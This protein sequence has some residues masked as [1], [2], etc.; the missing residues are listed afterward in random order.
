MLGERFGQIGEWAAPITSSSVDGELTV[1]A[2]RT[3]QFAGFGPFQAGTI[4]ERL[5]EFEPAAMSLAYESA[6]WMPSFVKSAVNRW[7]VR[8][9]S[10]ASCLR[11]GLTVAMS[12]LGVR[13][14]AAGAMLNLIV[15]CELAPLDAKDTAT[16]RLEAPLVRHDLATTRSNASL[17]SRDELRYKSGP[18]R[19]N[20]SWQ[21]LRPP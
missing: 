2:I 8:L 12:A 10:E 6:E 9:R 14:R 19:T 1:G 16:K 11:A 18:Q 7:S 15:P 17:D 3:C 4:H 21:K 20:G 5:L 13:V